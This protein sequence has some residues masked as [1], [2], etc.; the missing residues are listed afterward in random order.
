[1]LDYTIGTSL[2]SVPIWKKLHQM[3]KG[4]MGWALEIGPWPEISDYYEYNW[5]KK[6]L[7]KNFAL[8]PKNKTKSLPF[9]EIHLKDILPVIFVKKF[10]SKNGHNSEW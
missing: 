9:K 5:R 3:Q 7:A 10:L 8:K 6:Y 4:Q 1:M 2:N